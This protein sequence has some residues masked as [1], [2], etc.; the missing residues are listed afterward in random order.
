MFSIFK[1]NLFKPND[2]KLV[3]NDYAVWNICDSQ[4][5][6]IYER[7]CSYEIYYS[8]FR[9]EFKLKASGHRA[10]EH[11][12]YFTVVLPK[13]IECNKIILAHQNKEATFIE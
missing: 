2:W 7:K 3:W 10:K 13:F 1:F 6:S 11:N 9:G 8:Q 4:G 5:D 12:Y